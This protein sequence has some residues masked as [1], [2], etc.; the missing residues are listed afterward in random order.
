MRRDD[1]LWAAVSLAAG[2]LLLVVEAYQPRELPVQVSVGLLFIGPLVVACVGV[3]VRR[4]RPMLSLWCGVAAFCGDLALG[5]SLGT[6]LIVTDNFYAAVRY[7]PRTLGKRMLGVTSV[8]AVV[9]GVAAGILLRHVGLA[10]IFLVQ[11]AL[12]GVTPVSTGMIMKQLE[13]Q[14]AAERAKAEQVARLA[15]LDRAAAVQAERSRM[16]RELHDM[17]A[18]HF[19]AIAIQSTAVLSRKD[20]DAR[21]VRTVLESI[22]ENSVAGMGEMRAMIGL[23]RQDGEEPEAIRRRVA[24]AGELAERA[25]EA[26]LDVRLRVEGEARELPAP[27]D[28]AGYRIVQESLTNALKHGGKAADIVIGYRPELVTL[29]VDNPVDGA[30]RGLP[31]AGTGIIGMRERAT[32]VGGVLDAG[33]H[34]DGW[35]VRAELPTRE[36]T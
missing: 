26:G 5:P 36:I 13:D 25:R 9:V 11:A 15:E 35:R 6:M 14:A 19:S 33:P 1:A 4:T 18:N 23:L 29:T 21:S 16:A 12:I 17:I 2:L 31:G 24:E 34:D 30:Q 3:S 27:V 10:V 8:F 7:G 22:R 20:L 32:L 28:L